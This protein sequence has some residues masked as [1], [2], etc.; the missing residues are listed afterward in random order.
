MVAEV[1]VE[2]SFAHCW[3]GSDILQKIIMEFKEKYK[4]E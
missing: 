2:W 3:D 1:L 4:I